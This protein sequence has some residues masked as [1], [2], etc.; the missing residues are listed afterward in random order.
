MT[1]QE[2]S[3]Q[4]SRDI[5][6]SCILPA[7]VP[8]KEIERITNQQKK[9]FYDNYDEAVE[10]CTFIIPKS[11]F[12]TAAF[13]KYR[14]F[15]M[16]ENVYAITQA[17]TEIKG[18]NLYLLTK[19]ADLSA[20][21]LWASQIYM[22]PLNG[23][24]LVMRVAQ[25]H[26]FDLTQ[27]MTVSTIAFSYNNLTQ[28]LKIIGRDPAYDVYIRVASK[29]PEEKLFDDYYFQRWVTAKAKIS[30]ASILGRYNFNLI[31]EVSINYA[32]IKDEGKEEIDTIK[33]EIQG[34]QT[35]DFIMLWN[36]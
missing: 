8:P 35:A 14:E 2:F 28:K 23:D 26:F 18:H 33:E 7:T 27:A 20:D 31:G 21:R 1:L 34:K 16:P 30:L 17:P 3:V 22:S 15:K 32:D 25:Y 11:D 24:E 10:D 4:I 29:I 13:K 12:Q 9:W 6:S 19:D 36:G 5:T